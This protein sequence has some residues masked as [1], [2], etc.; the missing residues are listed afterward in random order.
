MEDPPTEKNLAR[1]GNDSQQKVIWLPATASDMK[2]KDAPNAE[3]RPG[4][5]LPWLMVSTSHLV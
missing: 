2:T 3:G 1:D 5:V 4:A